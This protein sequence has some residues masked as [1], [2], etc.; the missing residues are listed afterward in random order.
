M[1]GPYFEGQKALPCG[2]F[3]PDVVNVA[4]A[5]RG[6]GNYVNVYDC[7]ICGKRYDVPICC[8]CSDSVDTMDKEGMLVHVRDEDLP[9][10]RKGAI[11]GMF[12]RGH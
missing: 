11:S 8:T 2:H 3:F 4:D 5:R 9:A 1:P 12:V 10:F 7:S 6:P